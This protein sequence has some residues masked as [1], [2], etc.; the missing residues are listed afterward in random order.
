MRDAISRQRGRGYLTAAGAL[1]TILALALILP[2]STL[3]A[4]SQAMPQIS[5]ISPRSVAPGSGAFTL[6]VRGT[7][8]APGIS[9]IAWDGVELA[10][11]TCTAAAAPESPRAA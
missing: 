11:T 2:L 5:D 6:T 7:G 8:L 4:Q 9:R 1:F 3:R 10:G